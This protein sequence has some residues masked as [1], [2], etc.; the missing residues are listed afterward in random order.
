[1]FC[2]SPSSL[3]QHNTERACRRAQDC[4]AL[5][6]I[7]LLERDR[8]SPMCPSLLP[9][10][11]HGPRPYIPHMPR[12]LARHL[13]RSRSLRYAFRKFRSEFGI[14]ASEFMLSVCNKPLISL[15][16][17]GASGSVFFLSNDDQFIIKTVRKGEH[18]FM[19]R[20]LPG[21]YMVRL[22]LEPSTL[23]T[24]HSHDHHHHC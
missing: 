16:N 9:T 21:Y 24:T 17:P 20:L 22:S 6:F 8:P 19:L 12:A 11:P 15:S 10:T 4:F 7:T 3:R 23:Q 18:N 2:H 14:Q 5:A 1:M 13:T